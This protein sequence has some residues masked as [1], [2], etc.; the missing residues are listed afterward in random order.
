MRSFDAVSA[1]SLKQVSI[2][3]EAAPNIYTQYFA[4]RNHYKLISYSTIDMQ[5]TEHTFWY[6]GCV[7]VCLSKSFLFDIP[8]KHP[9]VSHS[10]LF[11]QSFSVKTS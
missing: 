5:L 2:R 3:L 6:N 11:F 1:L 7:L 9:K 10:K 8:K 4:K